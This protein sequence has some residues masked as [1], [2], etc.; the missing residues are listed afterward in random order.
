MDNTRGGYFR[1]PYLEKMVRFLDKMRQRHEAIDMMEAY[2]SNEDLRNL[3]IDMLIEWKM[4]GEQ[5][6]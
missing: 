3:Y 2:K 1:K 5:L 6:C 4:Y